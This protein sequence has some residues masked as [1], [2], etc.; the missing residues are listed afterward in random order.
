MKNLLLIFLLCLST[1]VI[2]IGKKNIVYDTAKVFPVKKAS[3]QTE[4]EIFADKDFIYHK[5]AKASKSWWDA[6]L[7]QLEKFLEWLFGKSIAKHPDVSYN[8]VK[9]VLFALFIA[10]LI[11]VLWKSKFRGLFKSNARISANPFDDLPENIEGINIDEHIRNAIQAGNYRLA[12]RWCFLKSLQW[13]NK[14]NKISWQTAKT[15]IDYLQEL[16]DKTLKEE[17]SSLSRVFE[18]VWYGETIPTEKICEEYKHK[19]EKFISGAHV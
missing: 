10:G 19:V 15:N 13:L 2:S 1:A 9:Y 18:Y 12:I 6:F 11:F 17:F 5:D 4:K 7:E 8:V 14:E 3:L 16:K